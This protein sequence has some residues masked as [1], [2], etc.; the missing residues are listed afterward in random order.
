MISYNHYASGAVGDFLYRRIL[1]IEPKEA[2]YRTFTVSPLSGSGLTEAEGTV[3]T[4]YGP[5]HCKWTLK[6]EGA[7]S[8]DLKV[9]VGTRAEV[10]LPGKE[11]LILGSGSHTIS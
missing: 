10:K 1:G 9:P 11:P 4:P 5:I 2:G 7:M 3:D 8:V 6:K